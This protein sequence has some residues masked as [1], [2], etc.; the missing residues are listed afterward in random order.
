MLLI[1]QRPCGVVIGI[2]GRGEVKIRIVG[3]AVAVV[4]VVVILLPIIVVIGSHRQG[5]MAGWQVAQANT[6][7]VQF[8]ATTHSH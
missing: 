6:G 1:Y 2:G 4:V 5:D 8:K 3:S 7:L